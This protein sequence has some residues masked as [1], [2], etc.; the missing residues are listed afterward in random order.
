MLRLVE[1][2]VVCLGQA[3]Q[4]IDLYRRQAILSRFVHNPKKCKD[5]LVSNDQLLKKEPK[6]LFISDFYT[7][8]GRRANGSIRLREARQEL[9][10]PPPKCRNHINHHH[11]N[12]SHFSIRPLVG[13]AGQLSKLQR[14]RSQPRKR[15]FCPSG[16]P[17]SQKIGNV[18]KFSTI[19]LG[20][21][22]G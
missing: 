2:T 11:H 8:L 1:Q 15:L 20:F 6:E 5:T 4:S 3:S 7:A 12:N 13:T 18:V 19:Y 14:Q 10:G 21:T 22:Q 17:R 9:T 16:P